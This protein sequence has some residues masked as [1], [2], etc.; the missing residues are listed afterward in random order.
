MGPNI[1]IKI[2]GENTDLYCQAYFAYDSKKSGGF[3]NSH[4]RFGKVPINS[5]YLVNAPNFVACHVTAYLHKYDMLAGLKDGG[6]FLLNSI[7]DKE[8]TLKEVPNHMKKYMAEHNINFYIINATKIAEEIGLGNRTNTIMQSAFFKVS[9]VIPYDKAKEEMKNFIVKSYGKKGENI[10][11]M[12]Y[13]AVEHGEDV[14]KIEIPSEWKDLEIAEAKD[15]DTTN[16]PDIVRILHK[17]LMHKRGT[18][19]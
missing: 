18:V 10:V 17:L 15:I 6:T 3:T 14:Q 9:E 7:Y 13:Q 11:N 19:L 2:I 8:R 12:N 16:V 4:L 5:P 1:P